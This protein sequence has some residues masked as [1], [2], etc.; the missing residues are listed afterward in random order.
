LRVQPPIQIECA[1]PGESL[2]PFCSLDPGDTVTV[3]LHSASSEGTAALLK[4]QSESFKASLPPGVRLLK[5]DTLTLLLTGRRDGRLFFKLLSVNG[6]SVLPEA[7]HLEQNLLRMG[8][9]PGSR[10]MRL[11]HFLWQNGYAPDHE[12]IGAFEKISAKAP[13]LPASVA[14]FMA[15]R[16]ILPGERES[17]LFSR[18]GH[19]PDRPPGEQATQNFYYQQIPICL[20]DHGY[21]AGLFVFRD[22]DRRK[23]KKQTVVFFALQTQNMGRVEARLTYDAGGL[24]ADFFLRS[25]SVQKYFSNHLDALKKT[26]GAN[27]LRLLVIRASAVLNPGS[28]S[29]AGDPNE[30]PK[31]GIDIKV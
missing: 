6:Q 24:T 31:G 3:A 10:N 16:G 1:S 15:E 12:M 5:G 4:T 19:L 26:L 28:P 27:G 13:G 29:A 17:S 20:R 23:A 9:P 21:K 8:I 25:G 7:S 11:A 2:H 14:A 30:T 18:P 22:K